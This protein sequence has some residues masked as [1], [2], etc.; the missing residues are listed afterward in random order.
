MMK[1]KK[2]N[3]IIEKIAPEDRVSLKNQRVFV[4]TPK[5]KKKS[6]NYY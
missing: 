5:M 4:Q 6:K 1:K 3:E 2:K